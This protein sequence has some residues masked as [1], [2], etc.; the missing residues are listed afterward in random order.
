MAGV[1]IIHDNAKFR[2]ALA[3][4]VSR[5]GHDTFVAPSLTEA[6]VRFDAADHGI[7]IVVAGARGYVE[8]SGAAEQVRSLWKETKVIVA[9]PETTVPNVMRVIDHILS[10]R[11]QAG[12]ATTVRPSA[13]DRAPTPQGSVRRTAVSAEP[14]TY[15]AA[16]L[17]KALVPIVRSQEDPRTID[18]W[19]QLIFASSGALRNWCRTGGMSP[20]RSLVFAR[21]LRAV[22]WSNNG[23][24]RLENLLDVVDRRTLAGLLRYAGLDPNGQLPTTIDEFLSKQTI[25]RDRDT[26]SAIRQVLGTEL[27]LTE[28]AV[29]GDVQAAVMPAS[30]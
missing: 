24:H 16:R 19:S 1:L 13:G 25:V 14:E 10:T 8:G 4:E 15:A 30:A 20:R 27:L 7:A 6:R 12:A 5:Q 26:L 2:M 3:D 11:H 9:H 21:L 28:P 17:A 18:A 23:E 29:R 22:V